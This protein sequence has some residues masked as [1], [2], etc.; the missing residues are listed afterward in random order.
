[1][2]TA[3]PC[4]LFLSLES[5]V[6]ALKEKF[7]RDQ[8]V[9][10]VA[11]PSFTADLDRLA[12]FRLLT[13]AEFED[14]LESK[15]KEGLDRLENSFAAGTKGIGANTALIVIGAM[16]G[17]TAKFDGALWVDFVKEVLTAAREVVYK[18]NGI[19]EGS[20]SNLAVFSG[21]MP[22]E[23]DVVLSAA[24][25][26]YGKQRGDV[27]HVSVLRVRSIRAPS[28]EVKDAEDLLQGLKNYF[29]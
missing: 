3:P 27:A 25:T 18:N 20:F 5:R 1:M 15:A 26:S 23:I 17:K 29:Y 14:F 9:A 24:L 10:E 21:K 13:H 22:D 2:A 28:A 19:K 7:V 8:L 4:Q 11:D 16:L 12:A 6:I